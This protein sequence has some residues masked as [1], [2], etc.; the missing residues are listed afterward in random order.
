M[1]QGQETA[2][3]GQVVRVL[4]SAKLMYSSLLS[5]GLLFLSLVLSAQSFTFFSVSAQCISLLLGSLLGLKIE[6]LFLLIGSVA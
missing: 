1:N 6:F 2:Q 4:R 3:H 5:K